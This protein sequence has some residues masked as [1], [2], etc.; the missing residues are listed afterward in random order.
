M[1][2]SRNDPRVVAA[3][4]GAMKAAYSKRGVVDRRGDFVW[5]VVYPAWAYKTG[6]AWC[7]GFM[8]WAYRQVGVDLMK[9]AWWFYTPY[10][11][12]FA[13][14]NRFWRSA[15]SYGAQP[16]YD[17]HGD[18]VAD[19]VGAA[20]P[21][22]ASSLYRAIEGNTSSGSAGSQSNG[23]GVYE[24]YRSRSRIMGWVDMHAVL[25]WMIDTGRWNGKIAAITPK[26]DV[27]LTLT[28]TDKQYM[29]RVD[30]SF[31]PASISRLQQVMGTPID[32]VISK[33]STVVRALQR[34]LNAAVGSGHMRNLIRRATLEVDGLW[35]AQTTKAL[36][37]LMGSWWPDLYKKHSGHAFNVGR[38]CDGLRGPI[39]I[40]VL[41][42]VLNRSYAGSGKL[43]KK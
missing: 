26:P 43:G 11:V 6:Y 15:S 3:V 35:G 42:E 9:C 37:F 17:W 21:D 20:N 39:T 23:G 14:N 40:R 18:G 28:K 16:L 8:V 30:G 2:T 33:P 1:V 5:S 24:R 10:I 32:G 41:Q 27:T 22:N 4:N 13:K 34:F 19:H 36:Q 29:L 38:D 25:A 12:N 31:G 7:G